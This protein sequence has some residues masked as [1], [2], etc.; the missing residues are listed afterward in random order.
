MMA[1]TTIN[2]IRVNPLLFTASSLEVVVGCLP[3]AGCH[4][5]HVVD[6]DFE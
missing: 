4:Y 1:M 6:C 3:V 5:V 2:S